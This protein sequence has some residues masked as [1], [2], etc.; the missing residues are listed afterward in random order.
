MKNYYKKKKLRISAGSTN[1]FGQKNSYLK[2]S[3]IYYHS[4]FNPKSP[5]GFDVSLIKLEKKVK[6]RRRYKNK[7]PYINTVCLPKEGKD[8]EEGQ[9]VKLA[10][11]GDSE[12]KDT[13]SKPSNLLTTDLKIADSESCA[14][15]FAEKDKKVKD[16]VKKQEHKYHDFICADYHGERDACQGKLSNSNR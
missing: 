8:F 7:L 14:K 2:I 10:G 5:I 11:W 1:A 12:Y 4:K 15:T 3:E 16:N 13:K 6:L 9:A